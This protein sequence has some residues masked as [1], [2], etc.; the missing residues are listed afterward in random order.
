MSAGDEGVSG[1]EEETYVEMLLK[2]EQPFERFF[3]A[4]YRLF[5]KTWREMHAGAADLPKVRA[6][7][8]KTYLK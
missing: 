8:Q 2:E 5:C 4:A 7:L 3:A 6:C 1:E